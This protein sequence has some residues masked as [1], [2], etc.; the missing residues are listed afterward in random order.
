MTGRQRI[1]RL[2]SAVHTRLAI[3]HKMLKQ[4]DALA[5]RDALVR[6]G[7]AEGKILDEDRPFAAFIGD[8]ISD[9]V[10]WIVSREQ[11]KVEEPHAEN[12]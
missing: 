8:S 1:G 7:W 3:A 4:H 10:E 11:K 2:I 12:G 5:G 6:S 9:A